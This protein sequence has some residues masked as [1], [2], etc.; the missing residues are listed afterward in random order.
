MIVEEWEEAD[1]GEEM[2]ADEEMVEDAP[3][4]NVSSSHNRPKKPNDYLQTLIPTLLPLIRPTSLS[5]APPF[6]QSP[7]PPTTSALSALHIAA[8]ECLN[9]ISLTLADALDGVS[10]EATGITNGAGHDSIA[11]LAMK[12]WREIW[13]MLATI[14]KPEG[15]GAGPERKKEAWLAGLGV[16][17][18]VG[19]IC[20][21]QLVSSDHCRPNEMSCSSGYKIPDAE[22]VQLLMEI[23]NTVPDDASKVKCIG[24]LECVAVHPSSVEANEVFRSLNCPYPK[25]VY[26]MLPK[27]ISSYLLSLLNGATI[28][29]PPEALIQAVSSIIDIFSD[30]NAPWDV[31]FRRGKWEN[32]LAQ[33]V[34]GVRKAVKSIDKRKGGEDGRELRRR[35]EEVLENLVAFVKY[36]RR[37]RL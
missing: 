19:R 4:I 2:E 34:D 29:Q 25:R 20:R 24:I 30:E 10:S 32:L 13:T 35:G 28:S 31:N 22:Q 33:S 8:L 11:S 17:W 7:H 12:T 16:L 1:E 14:G 9:N 36:R 15:V 26:S 21:G 3:P 18:A 23:C 27:V 5:Y 37:L 6:Q